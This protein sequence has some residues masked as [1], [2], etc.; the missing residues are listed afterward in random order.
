MFLEP[1]RSEYNS[2]VPRPSSLT[3]CHVTCDRHKKKPQKT[4]KKNTVHIS[5]HRYITPIVGPMAMAGIGNKPALIPRSRPPGRW[6]QALLTTRTPPPN[7]KHTHKHSDMAPNASGI[8]HMDHLRIMVPIWQFR[9]HCMLL[10]I[11]NVLKYQ[12]NCQCTSN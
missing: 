2:L 5:Y 4:Q 8:H 9:I 6:T 3:S 12:V 10:S 7:L 11:E 1:W